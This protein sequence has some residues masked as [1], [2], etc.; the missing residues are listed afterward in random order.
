MRSDQN[1]LK[2]AVLETGLPLRGPKNNP[3]IARKTSLDTI[4]RSPVSQKYHHFRRFPQGVIRRVDR[5]PDPLIK[6]ASPAA[7]RRAGIVVC[8]EINEPQPSSAPALRRNK[9]I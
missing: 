9:S 4:L 8:P 2:R 6:G 5:K 3:A 1:D 7:A